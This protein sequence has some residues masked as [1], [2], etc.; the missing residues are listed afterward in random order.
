MNIAINAWGIEEAGALIAAQNFCMCR[1]MMTGTLEQRPTS[2]YGSPLA[3]VRD[4][5]N[6]MVE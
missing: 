5:I 1:A 2:W 4:N 3:R 6:I